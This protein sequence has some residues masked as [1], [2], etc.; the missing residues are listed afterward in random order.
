MLGSYMGIQW[1]NIVVPGTVDYIEK[2][3]TFLLTLPELVLSWKSGFIF[4]KQHVKRLALYG[5]E[6]E[7]EK[8]ISYTCLSLWRCVQKV[9]ICKNPDIASNTHEL[10]NIYFKSSEVSCLREGSLMF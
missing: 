6:I 2:S 9:K 3:N 7:S 1:T 4:C 8:A 10:C 5:K